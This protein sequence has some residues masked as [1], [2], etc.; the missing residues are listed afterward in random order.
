MVFIVRRC[1]A[2]AVMASTSA[3]FAA[4]LDS[5]FPV[6][7]VIGPAIEARTIRRSGFR[8]MAAVVHC[9]GS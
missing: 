5:V 6:D 3:D 9:R 7:G 4:P 1:T 2:A 8:L